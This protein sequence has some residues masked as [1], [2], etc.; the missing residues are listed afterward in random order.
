MKSVFSELKGKVVLVNFWATWC[1]P[2][3][4]EFPDLIKL[5]N[6]YKDKAFEI[7]FISLD[8]P[9][10][11]DPKVKPFLSKNN[12]D[13]T[14]YYNNFK[15]PEEIINF[16]DKNWGGAIPATYIYDR[17]GNLSVSI[18]GSQRYDQFERELLKVLE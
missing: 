16:M 7:I 14:T 12:V 4:K 3:V 8:V 5:Y 6:N 13:F 1:K 9:E 10:E 11:I 15:Q 18:V 17:E 2:C